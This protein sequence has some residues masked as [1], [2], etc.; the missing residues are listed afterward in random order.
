[1]PKQS[2]DYR[3]Q[4]PGPVQHD[5]FSDFFGVGE[6]RPDGVTNNRVNA[7]RV[8]LPKS[9]PIPVAPTQQRAKTVQDL[10]V[11]VATN[12][13]YARWFTFHLNN[14]HVYKELRRLAL[15]AKGVE[16]KAKFGIAAIVEVARWNK[17]MRTKG[18]DY[19]LP[20]AYRA[21]Y[22]RLLMEQ[23]HHLR[24]FFDVAEL[25]TAIWPED[26]ANV[27]ERTASVGDA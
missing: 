26:Q 7:L 9:A 11:D 17:A 20:N 27:R 22:A 2:P 8:P 14:P 24:D 13:I 23:E 12:D 19:R 4:E 15:Q 21:M 16:G 3:P 6:V 25:R 10:A 1:M 5:L 18:E